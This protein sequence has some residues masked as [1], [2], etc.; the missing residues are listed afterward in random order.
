MVRFSTSTSFGLV[1]RLAAAGQGSPSIYLL[2]S[3]TADVGTIQ[4][5]IAAEVQVQLGVNLRSMAASEVPAERLDEA[6]RADNASLVVLFTLDRWAPD[7]IDWVDCN[8]VLVTR[9]GPV[10]LLTDHQLAERM[11]TAAPNLRNRLA[12]VLEIRPDVG[13]GG[14][15]A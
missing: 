11:L 13:F 4:A 15:R 6:F 14:A 10:L 2:I 12:D 9:G 1:R 8:I 5:D 7:L 3:E